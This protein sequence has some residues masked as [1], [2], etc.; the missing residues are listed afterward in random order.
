[1]ELT[2][3]KAREED[4]GTI[5]EIYELARK[6]QRDH[7]NPNQWAGGYPALDIVRDDLENG[8]LYVVCRKEKGQEQEEIAGVFMFSLR[9]EK[10][11]E[12][13]RE[14]RWPN[15]ELYGV[16]HRVASAGTCRGVGG[17]CLSWAW[18]QCPNLRMDTHRDN[19]VMRGLL[20][21]NGFRPCGLI[22]GRDGGERIAYQ[23]EKNLAK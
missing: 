11:Y 19:Y 13:I 9:P 1:M 10:D 22:T 7:G 23:K 2:I 18:E 5:M 4:L 21:K 3:R 16:I 17:A 14:G 15:E 12:Q 8:E 20:E 6:F